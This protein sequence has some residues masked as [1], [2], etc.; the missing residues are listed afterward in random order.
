MSSRWYLLLLSMYRCLYDRCLLL[1]HFSYLVVLLPPPMMLSRYLFESVWIMVF[2]SLSY[3]S[4][5]NFFIRSMI[6]SLSRISLTCLFM[7]VIS[8][9]CPSICVLRT[10]FSVFDVMIVSR[11]ISWLYFLMSSPAFFCMILHI[12]TYSIYCLLSTF[13]AISRRFE[14]A[15]VGNDILDFCGLL[16]AHGVDVVKFL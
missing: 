14:R 5:Y 11:M 1:S 13:P 2:C 15:R 7:S 6:L 9:S 10:F 4:V 12:S 8:L 3:D 16:I